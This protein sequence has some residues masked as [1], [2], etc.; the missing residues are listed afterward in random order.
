MPRSQAALSGHCPEPV[1]RLVRPTAARQA[2]GP[3]W[4]QAV[5]PRSGSSS[6]GLGRHIDT[7]LPTNDW[8]S[9]D[10]QPRRTCSRPRRRDCRRWKAQAC[11]CFTVGTGWI[12]GSAPVR[13]SPDGAKL[14]MLADNGSD[15][16]VQVANDGDVTA[17]VDWHGPRL[18]IRY[19]GIRTRPG[20]RSRSAGSSPISSG[21]LTPVSTDT[22]RTYLPDVARGRADDSAPLVS[23]CSA[24]AAKRDPSFGWLPRLGSWRSLAYGWDSRLDSRHRF[25]IDD[26][27]S[28]C[29]A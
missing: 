8:T 4:T 9:H 18:D 7:P 22:T 17:T 5:G 16:T 2:R 21:S 29:L 11:S 1:P 27:S 20:R 28:G 14:R 10:Y 25:V 6:T 12:C 15:I 26:L 19:D 23:V 24:G 3:P 13:K